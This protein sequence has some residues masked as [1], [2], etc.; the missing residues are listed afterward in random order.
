M[1]YAVTTDVES[2]RDLDRLMTRLNQPVID[3]D[4]VEDTRV[5]AREVDRNAR[6]GEKR[7]SRESKRLTES[8]SRRMCRNP[9][10][11]RRIDR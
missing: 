1:V 3:T 6:I 4:D 5:E 9:R 10:I 7:F 11:S 2:K 8:R